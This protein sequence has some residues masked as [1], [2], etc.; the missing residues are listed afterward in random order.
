[1]KQGSI[2]NRYAQALLELA[3][4]ANATAD[5]LKEMEALQAVLD[6]VPRLGTLLSDVIVVRSDRRRVLTDVLTQLSASELMTRFARYLLDKERFGL[7]ADI[8][9]AYRSLQDEAANLLRAKVVTATAL[10]SDVSSRVEKLLAD[11]TGKR[12]AVAYEE[13]PSLIGGI[14]IQLGSRVYDG[15][16]QG[17]LSRFQEKMLKETV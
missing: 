5:T 13:D 9:R 7:F 10:T 2:A 16:I 12:V 1:M 3:Q 6:Q 4:Q 17:E 11:K 8:V 14:K 15:T